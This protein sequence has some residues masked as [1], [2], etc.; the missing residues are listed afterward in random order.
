MKD[1]SI[2]Q[3]ESTKRFSSEL[4][5]IGPDL[6]ENVYFKIHS[7]YGSGGIFL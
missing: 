5:G 1:I 3:C 7:G 6:N 2:L 4:I